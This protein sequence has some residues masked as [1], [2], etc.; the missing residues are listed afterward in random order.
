MFHDKDD[1]NFG[2]HRPNLDSIPSKVALASLYPPMWSGS[3]DSCSSS[4]GDFPSDPSGRLN[5]RMKV[6]I[7]VQKKQLNLKFVYR[8]A[9]DFSG[10][11]ISAFW[12][13]KSMAKFLRF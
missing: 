12:G 7:H 4:T 6:S 11:K 10:R 8:K 3:R 13:K 5:T 1:L 9:G 2:K